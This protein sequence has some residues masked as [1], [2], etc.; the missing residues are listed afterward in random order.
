M[1]VGLMVVNS[2]ILP[3]IITVLQGVNSNEKWRSPRLPVERSFGR[4][5]APQACKCL[6][7]RI[8]NAQVVLRSGPRRVKHTRGNDRLSSGL[9]QSTTDTSKFSS[10]DK[11]QV[12]PY[13]HHV[14]LHDSLLNKLDQDDLIEHS[15]IAT[16]RCIGHHV[17]TCPSIDFLEAVWI[18]SH[19][20]TCT[21]SRTCCPWLVRSSKATF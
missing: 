12:N 21:G 4:S 15:C 5:A 20:D 6:A 3:A 7:G 10:A 16:S 19:G 2:W 8:C 9:C 13:W 18:C 11:F 17:T 1:F 14:A